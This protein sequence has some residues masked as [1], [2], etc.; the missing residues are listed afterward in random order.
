MGAADDMKRGLTKSLANFTKQRKAEEKHSSAG[1]WRTSRMMEVRGKFLTEAANEV[2]EE[3]YIKASDNNR[4]PAT[5]RQIYYVARPLI[6][7]RT[8]KPLSYAY[9]S[10]TLLPNFVNEHGHDWDVVYDDR[11]HFVEP[12]TNRLIGL[13]TL[14]VRAYLNRIDQLKL[15]GADFD[16]ASVTEWQLRRGA[17]RREGRIYAAVQAGQAGEA[18]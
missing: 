12:H 7:E 5:A 4:L 2:I 18:L 11:G 13:G 8:D 16:P 6:E 17:L 10:Q 3:C 9:F 14:S 1:R 15:E